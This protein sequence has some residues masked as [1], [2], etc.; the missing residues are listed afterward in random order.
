MGIIKE[1]IRAKTLRNMEKIKQ[2][3]TKVKNIE[4][5]EMKIQKYLLPNSCK[6]TKE[7]AQ[8][9]FKL[10]CRVVKVK[11]NLKGM[12][13]DLQCRACGREEG[14]GPDG[15]VVKTKE[16]HYFYTCDVAPVV[17][18]GVKGGKLKQTQVSQ[19]LKTTR[20]S[21]VTVCDTTLG[22]GEAGA[23]QND[24]S[25]TTHKVGQDQTSEEQV[26]IDR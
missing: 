20:K 1:E 10:R 21:D 12:F 17:V 2:Y 11:N 7:E 13:D 15:K 5:K 22:M 9:I 18:G 25:S 8:M 3:H 4:Y 26:E 14:T 6:M 24:F 16:R 23:V 19:F